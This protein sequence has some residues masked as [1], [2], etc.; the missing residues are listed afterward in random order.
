MN[1]LHSVVLAFGQSRDL[2]RE[3]DDPLQVL[4]GDERPEDG[5]NAD[6]FTLP[7]MDQL[8]NIKPDLH[9]DNVCRV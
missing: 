8:E 4:D 6:G 5:S 9:F 2:E 7:C 1:G 3:A